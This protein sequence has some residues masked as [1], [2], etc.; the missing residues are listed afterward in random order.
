MNFSDEERKINEQLKR[1]KV[2]NLLNP[3]S[4]RVYRRLIENLRQGIFM[5]DLEGRLFYVNTSFLE[6]LGYATKDEVLGKK[7]AKHIFESE[8]QKE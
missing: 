3:E 4:Q 6:I 7:T 1:E 2:Y 8:D 5:A